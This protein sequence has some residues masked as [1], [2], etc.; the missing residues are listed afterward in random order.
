[1]PDLAA[2]RLSDMVALSAALRRSGTAA[3][4]MEDV[5][6]TVVRQLYD[7]LV[8][9]G[10][11][12]CVLVRFFKTHRLDQLDE[13]AQQSARSLLGGD[14]LAPSTKC[15]ALLASAGDEPRWNDRRLSAG[16]Q[17]VPLASAEIIERF[18]M[19]SQLFRQLGVE[20]SGLLEAD[21]DLVVRLDER[22]YN[23]FHVPAAVGSVHIP[24]QEDFVV[25]YGV[26]SVVG[27]GG[28][29]ATG[30]LFAVVLFSRAAV[31]AR[32]AELFETLALS[33]KVAVQPFARG[34]IFRDQP[35]S[36]P[37]RSRRHQ[38]RAVE[39]LLGVHER[40]VEV[41]AASLEQAHQRELMRS[42]QLRTLAD[43]T[44]LV[45]RARSLD[46][47]LRLVTEQARRI[48]GASQASAGLTAD[49]DPAAGS[50]VS[51]MVCETNLPLRAD[52]WLGAPLISRTGQNM[53][54]L[55]LSERH[56]GAFTS[57]DEA[58]LVQLA[59]IASV[60]VEN[61][62]AYAREHDLATA[63]QHSLLPDALPALPGLDIA[64]R[65]LPGT[66]DVEVGGD[67][68]DVL[69]VSDTEVALIIGDVVGHDVAA[70][71]TM[72]RVRHA[73][74]AYAVE[75]PDPASVLTR[76]SRFVAQ[77]PDTF[78]TALY[79]VLD[80]ERRE[81]RIVNAGHPPALLV[82][83]VTGTCSYLLADVFP[84]VGVR[85]G[86][87]YAETRAVVPAGSTI[88]LYT[89][90][91]IERR[92]ESIDVGLE[93]LRAASDS[94]PAGASCLLAHLLDTLPGSTRPDD[95]ALLAARLPGHPD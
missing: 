19:I 50:E 5:A 38:V 83:D 31:T 82:D 23:V 91:L 4:S 55:Q 80:V 32:T 85:S 76:L 2:L 36:G 37:A 47:I 42:Q 87:D 16:H 72:G 88:V 3:Q 10:E 90:G 52:G 22:T 24:A 9:D 57:D 29:L 54:L 94:A 40:T 86:R 77:E 95:I 21:P 43:A 15:L 81:V 25:P 84:P 45:S 44:V 39:Q 74:Q 69:P 20:T 58:I 11:R 68:Y 61:A 78:T 62:L 89:D 46:E 59:Q 28:M 73:I 17:A 60:T 41:Q 26:R 27:F 33:V 64:V 79:M 18:P 35:S 53:G 65:Y 48:I 49:G 6:G 66:A 92:G 67:F 71:I 7:G 12:N 30:D 14:A 70:A 63:L 8:D 51:A 93:R 56:E 13:S 75:D 34:P 1:V